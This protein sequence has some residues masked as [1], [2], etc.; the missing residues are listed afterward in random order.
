MHCS[1]PHFRER[2]LNSRPV[3]YLALV[4]IADEWHRESLNLSN[5]AVNCILSNSSILIVVLCQCEVLTLINKNRV[6][7][8]FNKF[9]VFVLHLSFFFKVAKNISE[10]IWGL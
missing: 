3:K 4:L 7:S 5:L 2:K 1:S 9:T 8:S 10:T 6:F